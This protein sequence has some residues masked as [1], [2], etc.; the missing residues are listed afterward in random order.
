FAGCSRHCPAGNGLPGTGHGEPRGPPARAGEDPPPRPDQE[1]LA[2]DRVP[3]SVDDCYRRAV[4][5]YD[6][7]HP[8]RRSSDPMLALCMTD[9]GSY[10]LNQARY[11]EAA[12]KFLEARAPLAG[13]GPESPTQFFVFTWC[14]EAEAFRQMGNWDAANVRLEAAQRDAATLREEDRR[15]LAF[16]REHQAWSYVTQWRVD[17][18]WKSFDEAVKIRA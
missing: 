15:L 3:V 5:T 9:W 18:A 6:E 4:E 14:K 16:A 10:C 2:K 1:T 7:E 13:V 8:E 17:D 12:Q 11:E